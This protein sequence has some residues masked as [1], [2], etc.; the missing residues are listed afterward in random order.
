MDGREP[1]GGMPRR[2]FLAASLG[3]VAALAL[4]GCTGGSPKPSPTRT[5]TPTPTPLP[6]VA[7]V[8]APTAMARSRW[9]TDARTLGGI[10]FE[11]VGGGADARATLAGSVDGRLWFASDAI[12]AD[13][14]NP[15]T[16]AAARASGLA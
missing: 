9:S 14:T 8:P 3:G 7:G 15:G 12:S 4:A 5:P 10:V 13:G 16:I 11:P 6:T 1:R 2:T